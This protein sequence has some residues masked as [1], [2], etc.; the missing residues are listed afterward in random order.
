MMLTNEVLETYDGTY[1]DWDGLHGLVD[2]PW[3]M[4]S[5]MVQSM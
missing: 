2:G 3:L 4:L 1:I 5:L